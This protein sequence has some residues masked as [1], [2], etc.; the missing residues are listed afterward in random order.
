[1]PPKT[2]FFGFTVLLTVGV[3][4]ACNNS[5]SEPSGEQSGI[6][7]NDMTNKI[8]IG[9]KAPDFSL[10]DQYGQR[11]NL[12]DYLG[13]SNL[14]LFFY[15]KDESYGCTREACSFRDNYEVFKSAGTVVIGISS[16]D[17]ASHQAFA[18]NH[19][20]PFILLSDRDKTVAEKYGVGK[21]L[22]ILPGRV[23]FVI[24]KQGVIQMIFS[25]QLNFEKHVSEA[26]ETLKKI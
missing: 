7:N 23:T 10:P 22:G 25:S 21:S 2:F 26:I 1:M 24:D 11:V 14:V 16:D 3:L 19:K 13:K 12:S 4:Y 20:L 8:E 15:P 6:I 18:A 9:S 17:V 5:Q